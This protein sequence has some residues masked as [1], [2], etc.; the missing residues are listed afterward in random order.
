MLIIMA[1]ACSN[2]RSGCIPGLSRPLGLEMAGW[3]RDQIQE[4]P[5]TEEK[6]QP[7]GPLVAHRIVPFLCRAKSF[8]CFPLA[9][10]A[11]PYVRWRG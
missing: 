8:G 1:V 5:A 4:D 6:T 7:R 3:F 10:A 9:A 11:I 2:A